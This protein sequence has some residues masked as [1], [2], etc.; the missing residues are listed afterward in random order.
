MWFRVGN[1]SICCTDG[2]RGRKRKWHPDETEG[3]FP[4]FILQVEIYLWGDLIGHAYLVDC[5]RR[6][7]Y[8]GRK[9]LWTKMMSTL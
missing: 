9:H 6:S 1:D 7:R 8:L 4:Q 5:F 3:K 2:P